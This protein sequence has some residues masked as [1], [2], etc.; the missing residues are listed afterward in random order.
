MI[1]EVTDDCGIDRW[2]MF[3]FLISLAVVAEDKFNFGRT[4]VMSVA[5]S[6]GKC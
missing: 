2:Q 6:R 4:A 1:K 3:F 5:V